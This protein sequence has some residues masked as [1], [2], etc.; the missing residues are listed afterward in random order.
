M[1]DVIPDYKQKFKI[2]FA[3]RLIKKLRENG[4]IS[5]RGANGVNGNQ[6]AKGIG[7]SLTMARRYINGQS[8]PENPVLQKIA[9]WL[10]VEPI[11]LLCGD[12]PEGHHNSLQ[13][14]DK[15]LLQEIFSQLFPF[16]CGPTLTKDQYMLLINNCLD[17]YHNISSMESNLPP[18]RAIALMIK[19]LAQN[20]SI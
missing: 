5:R 13:N 15:K 19:F 16:F 17:I 7:V 1:A 3:T 14:Q 11:W 6:L 18:D 4:Y 8:L 20:H 2:S 12:N 10:G 9:Q